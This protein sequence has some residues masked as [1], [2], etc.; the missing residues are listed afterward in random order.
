M[1]RIPGGR[2]RRLR[3][4]RGGPLAAL[5]V[6]ALTICL[7]AAVGV[8]VA[9]AG[10]ARSAVDDF[11]GSCDPQAETVRALG[12]TS[13][14][15][16]A[17]GRLLGA[18][19]S[20]YY[21]QRVGR[22]EM[23][24]WIVKATLAAEDRRFYEHGAI[25]VRGVA[26]A[27]I[28]NLKA[29]R[30]VEG[31]STLTQQL[32]RNL[33]SSVSTER[34]WQ[35]KRK[36]AC[37]AIKLERRWSKDRILAAY[38]NRAY[39][40]HRAYGI[41]AAAQTYFGK[42]AK[43]LHAAQAA[44]LAGLPQSPSGYDP[45]SNPKAALARR[46][47]VLR[48]MRDTGALSEKAY[49]KLVKQ[50][51][52]LRPG[53]LYDVHRNPGFFQYVEQQLVEAYGQ[54]V[55]REGGLR[56]Y[57]T[58]IP[59][60]QRLAKQAIR[61]NLGRRTDPAAAVVTIDPRNGAIRAMAQVVPGG[62]REDFNLA[63]QGRRQA[64]SSFKTFVLVQAMAEHMNPYA[65]KYLSAPFKYY[66][67]K[68]QPPWEPKT[69][70]GN[71]YGP[72]TIVQATLRSDNSVYARLTV[73]V[74]PEDV[75]RRAHQMGIES[76]LQPVPSIGLGANS[77]TPLEMASAYATLA[78]GGIYRE[79][80][81]IRKVVLRSGEV[82]ALTW[83]V[84]KHRAVPS[85]IAY[86]A[87]KILER[88]VQEGTGTR[89]R[90]GRPAAGKTG[91]TDHHTDAWF[92]G[93]TPRLATAVWVGYP[94][95]TLS[96][97]NVHGI[98]VAGG[99]FPAQIWGDY[100]SRAVGRMQPVSWVQPHGSWEW[101]TWDKPHVYHAPPPPKPKATTGSGDAKNAGTKDGGKQKPAKKKTPTKKKP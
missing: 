32:V 82:D 30:V 14:V 50:K 24:P 35:R 9:G 55:V 15:Y 8:A 39:Y 100:T 18:I 17:N 70:S 88:N 93:F 47:A 16:D 64:G 12:E 92:V 78:A 51:L 13:F 25:D 10:V 74:G 41:E 29:G 31:A 71:Y 38:L 53:N 72:S 68:G 86:H 7:L 65:T 62:K 83:K 59:R 75:A 1:A 63:Y 61:R 96:M 49:R 80:H 45:L 60:Y 43:H 22:D 21:R 94:K 87:T 98:R 58:I 99:T 69:Y 66:V 84:H 20:D 37:L 91:T 36:E 101:R 2:R 3:R 44:L 85:P 95:K 4:Q 27:A 73:D 23:S 42:G 33:Y 46:N 81:A 19:R 5:L 28:H 79:P 76:P 34:T 57:T 40:G 89:A 56:V 6:S 48:S 11:L 54:Q 90:I 52:G 26:R 97:L 77:V 67:G